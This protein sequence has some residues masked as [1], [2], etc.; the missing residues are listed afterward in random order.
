MVR[1]MTY[2]IEPFSLEWTKT[3]VGQ[4]RLFAINRR[5]VRSW[6]QSGHSSGMN[7]GGVYN[8]SRPGAELTQLVNWQRLQHHVGRAVP[9]RLLIAVNDPPLTIDRQAFGGDAPGHPL[10]MLR[11]NS[12]CRR[13]GDIAA[14]ALQPAPLMG[15]TDAGGMQGEAG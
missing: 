13:A 5:S 3:A 1:L 11:I 7:F 8:R 14:Q 4:L 2:S 15:L 10:L 9:E 6:P 12:P